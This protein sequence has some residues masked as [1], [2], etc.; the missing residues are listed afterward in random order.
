MRGIREN[1]EEGVQSQPRQR[2]G[3]VK[4]WRRAGL[5]V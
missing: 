2:A 3:V 1:C 4:E 5:A